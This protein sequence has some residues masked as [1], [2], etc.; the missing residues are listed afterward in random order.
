MTNSIRFHLLCYRFMKSQFS[1]LLKYFE[2]GFDDIYKKVSA[3]TFCNK[4]NL[5]RANMVIFLF[6]Q[7]FNSVKLVRWINASSVILVL[8][9]RFR[10]FN[11]VNCERSVISLF[12]FRL[13]FVREDKCMIS[14]LQSLLLLERSN[15]SRR[16]NAESLVTN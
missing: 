3:T 9:E 2:T 8:S 16:G 11:C 5:I 1:H 6:L 12:P 13:R 10:V 15:I 4:G 7:R 14:K